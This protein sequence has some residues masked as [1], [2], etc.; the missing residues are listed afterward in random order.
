MAA[1]DRPY[2]ADGP[3]ES[4][5]KKPVREIR[6]PAFAVLLLMLTGI[7]RVAGAGT[8]EVTVL[9]RDGNP[10]PDVAV[11]VEATEHPGYPATTKAIAVMD[12]YDRR[13]VPHLLVVQT[14]TSV[15]FPN[16]DTIAHHVYSFSHP[17]H[18]KLPIY[19]G[20][21][22]PPVTFDDSGIVILGCNIHDNMLG[23]ILVV[24]TPAFAKT[25]ADGRAVLDTGLTGDGSVSVWS[26]RIR[27][28]LDALKVAVRADDAPAALTV[29]L[30]KSLRPAHPD[31]SETLSWSEY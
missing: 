29:Q 30:A 9:D 26:P 13:F 7:G 25:D 8:I 27:D 5:R 14:G 16:S 31:D 19:K 21:A 18:F 24:D 22:H 23:Y 17:N 4:G 28:D 1:Y 10:V 2:T 15:E 12:Q 6:K 20:D 11:F 3:A